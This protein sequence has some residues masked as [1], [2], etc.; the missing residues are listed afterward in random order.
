MNSVKVF[1]LNIKS[2]NPIQK[3][4]HIIELYA[5]TLKVFVVMDKERPINALISLGIS[6]TPKLSIGQ[7][8][9][10]IF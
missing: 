10:I 3:Y 9:I 4:P 8:L 2:I 1:H 7:K 5:F 6:S